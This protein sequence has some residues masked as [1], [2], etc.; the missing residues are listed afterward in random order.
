MTAAE[1]N[2]STEYTGEVLN[3][4]NMNAMDSCYGPDCVQHDVS[5]SEVRTMADYERRTHDLM[6]GLTDF[7]YAVDDLIA[8]DGKAI[9]Q[10]TA[11]GLHHSTLARIPAKG[12]RLA[13]PESAFTA[14]LGTRLQRDGTFTTCRAYC[15]NMERYQHRIRLKPELTDYIIAVQHLTAPDRHNWRWLVSSALGRLRALKP[16]LLRRMG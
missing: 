15:N 4:G 1:L 2:F 6:G 13:S 10:W 11:R 12:K 3:K 7:N 8:E 5:G 9:K 14:W 16:L